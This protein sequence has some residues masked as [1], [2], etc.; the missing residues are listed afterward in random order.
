MQQSPDSVSRATKPRKSLVPQKVNHHPSRSEIVGSP[1]KND[2]QYSLE[3]RK[4][5]EKPQQAAVSGRGKG[6]KKFTRDLSSNRDTEKK[7]GVI[8]AL[9]QSQKQMEKVQGSKTI[10]K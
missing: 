4:S 6:K 1:P 10:D 3:K 9:T 8:G 5:S 2:K 7:L